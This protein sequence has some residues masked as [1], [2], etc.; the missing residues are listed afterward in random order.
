MK[1][2]N[3]IVVAGQEGVGKSTVVRALLPRTNPGAQIDA[4]DLGQINPFNF[5]D[6][7]KQLLWKNVAVLTQNYWSAGISTVIA[8]SFVNDYRAYQGFRTYLT[9]EAD[10]YLVHLCASK[11]TRDKRRIDRSKPSTQEWRNW[12]DE[13]YPEDTS[14]RLANANYRYVRVENDRLSVDA[15]VD[16]VVASIPNVYAY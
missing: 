8:G 5:D 7:F 3:L 9:V 10:I 14:L 16:Q 2:F 6:P 12:L 4:E 1:R 13:H 15:T 11:S